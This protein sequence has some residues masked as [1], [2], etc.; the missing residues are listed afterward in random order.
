MSV[1]FECT[2]MLNLELLDLKEIYWKEYYFY[3]K[4]ESSLFDNISGAAPGKIEGG[5]YGGFGYQTPP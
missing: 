3:L 5:A 4:K 1:S 2:N